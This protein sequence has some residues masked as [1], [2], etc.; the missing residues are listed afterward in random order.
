MTFFSLISS[1][2]FSL[3]EIISV[4]RALIS[5]DFSLI[6]IIAKLLSHL[7]IEINA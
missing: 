4:F 1:Y 3:I 6:E 5:H 2:D 7:D